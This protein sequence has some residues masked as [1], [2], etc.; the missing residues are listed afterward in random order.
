MCVLQIFVAC[1]KDSS[2]GFRPVNRVVV[3]YKTF[4]LPNLTSVCQFTPKV[5]FGHMGVLE[6]SVSMAPM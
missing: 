5:Y 6:L 1:D 3:K 2:T 4:N